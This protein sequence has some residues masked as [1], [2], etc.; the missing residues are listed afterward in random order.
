MTLFN[1]FVLSYLVLVVVD[2]FA[3]WC[4]NRYVKVQLQGCDKDDVPRRVYQNVTYVQSLKRNARAIIRII[5][6]AL[7]FLIAATLIVAVGS[8]IIIIKE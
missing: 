5:Q 7:F 6:I 4:C 2:D 3:I 8:L 1:I